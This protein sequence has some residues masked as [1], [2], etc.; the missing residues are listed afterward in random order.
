MTSSLPVSVLLAA[1]NEETNIRK[2]LSSL[3]PAK[4]II[5][6]DSQSS[7]DTAR[8][9]ADEFG[10]RVIQFHYSGDYPKKRQ[11]A[12]ENMEFAGDW[13]LLLDAD[14]EVPERL[15]QE[16]AAVV[17]SPYSCSAFMIRKGF[18]F[19]G[20]KFRFGGFSHNALVLFRKGTCRFEELVEDTSSGLD[21]EVHERVITDGAID[22][23]KTPLIH[24]D[25]KG[26]EAY[27]A[28]HNSY[29]S[30]EAQLRLTYFKK[31]AYGQVTIEPRLFGNSQERRRFL[32]RLIIRLPFEPT[33]WFLYHYVIR[34]GFLEGW[35]G[36]VA[37]RIRA[38]YI[39]Q[40]RAKMQEQRIKHRLVNIG[41]DD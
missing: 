21:M 18:H 19:L 8:I 30:W 12:L 17:N 20:R 27:I 9:A 3:S 31:G 37:C 6:V 2:C 23:L 16:I 41:Q 38:Q 39:F 14:E 22:T 10:V 33:I 13:I 7:D 36:F 5:L 1:K 25:F 15:W 24:E 32:K 35:A 26:L 40:V 29:S 28:R 4:E 11:W 34:F